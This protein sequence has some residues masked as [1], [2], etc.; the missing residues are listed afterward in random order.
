MSRGDV[1]APDVLHQ[2]ASSDS[3]VDPRRGLA[4][5]RRVSRRAVILTWDPAV[6]DAFWL[7]RDYFPAII[8]DDLRRFPPLS[9]FAE[10]WGL[11]PELRVVPVPH[12][13]VDGFLGAY[14]RRPAAYLDPEVRRG[15]S[16]FYAR[17]AERWAPGLAALARDLE[18]GAWARRHGALLEREALDLGYRLVIARFDAAS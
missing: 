13:C 17:P 10:V 7:I 12:D 6:G 5:L 11:D 3:L 18:D 15:I 8:E 9:W 1:D 14:W 4:E 2:P 16:S